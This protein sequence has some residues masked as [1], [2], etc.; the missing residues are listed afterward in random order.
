MQI[1][2]YLPTHFVPKRPSSSHQRFWIPDKPTWKN[3]V[4]VGF[5]QNHLTQVAPLLRILSF[6]I[7]VFM[8]RPFRLYRH[9]YHENVC[10]LQLIDLMESNHGLLQQ[11]P[12][13]PAPLNPNQS[14]FSV[15]TYACFPVTKGCTFAACCCRFRR[16]SFPLPSLKRT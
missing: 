12:T 1:M 16:I 3:T 6:S 14:N 9:T 4:E 5:S 2:V 8:L 7:L 15:S 13:P 10:H 11:I